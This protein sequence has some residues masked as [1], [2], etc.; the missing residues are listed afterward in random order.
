[1]KGL[2]D[3]ANSEDL[4]S[5]GK[6]ILFSNGASHGDV[7]VGSASGDQKPF[8]FFDSGFEDRQPRF[9][10]DGKWIAY[11]SNESGRFEVYVRPFAGVPAES[12]QK[13]QISVQGGFYATWS[14]DGQELFFIGPDAKLYATPTKDVSSTAA[15]LIAQALF[16]VCS[17]NI[18]TGSAT[19]GAGFDVAPDGHRFLFVCNNESQNRYTVTVNW[20]APK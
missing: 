14:R 17:G 13:T 11:H 7:W 8:R 6:W 4:S 19:Q 20:Q 12:G 5:D 16:T 15:V 2:P 18:P 9:S 3:W 10:P 1:V